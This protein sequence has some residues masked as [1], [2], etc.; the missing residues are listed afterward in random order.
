[1]SKPHHGLM[2]WMN[3]YIK[4]ECSECGQCDAPTFYTLETECPFW[5]EYVE[6]IPRESSYYED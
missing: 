5:D 6:Q 1:M 3:K 2:Y 4:E